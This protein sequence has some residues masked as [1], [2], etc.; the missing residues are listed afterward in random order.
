MST[1]KEDFKELQSLLFDETIFA[2]PV[3][4]TPFGGS[5]FNT[6]AKMD[7]LLTSKEERNVNIT[8]SAFSFPSKDFSAQPEYK[9]KFTYLGETWNVRSIADK[10]VFSY[11]VVAAKDYRGS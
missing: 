1:F 9:D 10:N 7:S 11:K 6:T 2:N 8:Y 3:V 4:Y 5:S